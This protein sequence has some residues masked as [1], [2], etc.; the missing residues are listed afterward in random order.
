MENWQEYLHTQVRDHPAWRSFPQIQTQ[1]IDPLKQICVGYWEGGNSLPNA[2]DLVGG[3]T[4]ADLL[5]LVDNP[6]AATILAHPSGIKA[7]RS[8]QSIRIGYTVCIRNI[9]DESEEDV[10]TNADN[11]E[12]GSSPPPQQT[13]KPILRHRNDRQE[14]LKIEN[15]SEASSSESHCADEGFSSLTQ[16]RNPISTHPA[17]PLQTLRPS[18][19]HQ[20]LGRKRSLTILCPHQIST[21]TTR[22][23]KKT[24]RATVLAEKPSTITAQTGPD[25]LDDA[26]DTTV[27]D[28]DLGF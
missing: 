8:N 21:K 24:R 18:T 17:R 1:E 25:L 20:L 22:E 14:A 6:K 26:G 13:E 27:N 3:G 5:K 15:E 12:P 23:L 11:D 19:P 28:L 9:G 7:R 4:I 16:E 2:N 10:D